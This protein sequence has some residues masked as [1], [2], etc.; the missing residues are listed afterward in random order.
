MLIEPLCFK[1]LAGHL[2]TL[3]GPRTWHPTSTEK[4][5]PPAESSDIR[6]HVA[7]S[8]SLG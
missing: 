5:R 1:T 6:T 7:P 8:V 4:E 2:K 3:A